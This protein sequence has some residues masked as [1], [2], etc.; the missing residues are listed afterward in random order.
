MRTKIKVADSFLSWYERR[1]K[2][3]GTSCG[4]THGWCCLQLITKSW[5]KLIGRGKQ[6]LFKLRLI[7]RGFERTRLLEAP[8]GTVP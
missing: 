8:Q 4:A 7:Y 5:V 1:Y 3:R 6:V 2:S